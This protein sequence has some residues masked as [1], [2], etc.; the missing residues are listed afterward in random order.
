MLEDYLLTNDHLDFDGFVRRISERY[1]PHG[2]PE[3]EAV[4]ALAGVRP[5]YL[6]AAFDAIEAEFEGVEH[7]IERA[8]G[9]DAQ[10][11]DLLRSRFL[12]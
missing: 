2:M 9:L 6:R 5:E 7:Y 4:M 1:E 12:I 3:R 10:A 8:V 11:R